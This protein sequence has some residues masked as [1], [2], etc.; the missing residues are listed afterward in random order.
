MGH[1]RSQKVTEGHRRSQEVTEGHRRSLEITGG[2]RRSFEVTRGF[3]RSQ[4][5][6]GS[7]VVLRYFRVPKNRTRGEKYYRTGPGTARKSMQVL[8]SDPE[9]PSG[10]SQF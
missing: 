1:R 8:E 10:S 5:V 7:H 6:I 3:K 4:V 9:P 2:H